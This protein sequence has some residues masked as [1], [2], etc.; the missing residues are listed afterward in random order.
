ML[1]NLNDFE[2]TVSQDNEVIDIPASKFY[3]IITVTA[4]GEGRVHTNAPRKIV[5]G[6]LEYVNENLDNL[7]YD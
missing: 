2:I 5:A 3:L 4:A 6:L 1:D 7:K